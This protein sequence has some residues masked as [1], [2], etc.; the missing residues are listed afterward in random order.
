MLFT[1][2]VDLFTILARFL[3]GGL[4]RSTAGWFALELEQAAREQAIRW[5]PR[6]SVATAASGAREDLSVRVELE[7]RRTGEPDKQYL[8]HLCV[9]IDGPRIPRGLSFAAERGTG[10]DVLTGDTVFDDIVEVRGE[11][12]IL[13]A[14]LDQQIRQRVSEF[15]RLGGRLQSGHLASC[16]PASFSQGE[17]VRVLRIGLW[18]GRELSSPGGGICERLGQN[19]KADPHSGVRLLNLLQLH[20]QFPESRQAREASQVDLKDQSPWVRLAAA[21]FLKAEGLEV[22]EH[23]AQDRSAPESAVAEAVALLAAHCPVE[24]AGPVLLTA[25]KTHSGEA[26]RQAVEEIGRIRYLGARGPL[27]VLLERADPRTGVAAATAL[28]ALGDA[29]AEAALLKAVE[30]DAGELRLAA[31]RALGVVGSAGSVEPLLALLDGRR[32]DAD[33]RHEL[34]AAVRAIQS[35]LAGAEAGQLSLA[36]PSPGTGWLSVA[37]PAAGQGQL[38][39]VPDRKKG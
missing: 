27:L 15:V 22:L 9:A 35:R 31:I 28:A 37:T 4:D 12:S 32:L 13:L 36:A 21:R 25:L 29:S 19:A 33:T 39:L 20:E 7:R 11:P 1:L 34:G 14:L 23:L 26:R 24:R 5:S 30:S 10:D 18:L 8:D 16:A 17:L 38:S 6:S 3:R 2:L